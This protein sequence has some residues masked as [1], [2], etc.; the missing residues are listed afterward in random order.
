MDP[1]GSRSPRGEAKALS[2]Q[3]HEPSQTRA[4]QEGRP[5][6][7]PRRDDWTALRRFL[8]LGSDGG[9]Y[10][11]SEFRLTR[12]AADAVERCIS[13]DGPRTVAEIVALCHDGRAPKREPALFALALAASIGDEPTRQVALDALPEV[14]RSSVDLFEFVAFVE[15]FRGWGRALRR[16]VGAWYATRPVDALAY[17]AVKHR[18]RPDRTHRDL[19]RLSHP[20]EQVSARNPTQPVSEEH[21]RLFEWIVRGGETDGLP[22]IVQGFAAAQTAPEPRDS[23]ALVGEYGLPPE[24]LRDEHLESDEV[25]AAL[26]REMP[27]TAIVRQLAALTEAGVLTAGSPATAEVVAALGN[28]E[29]VRRARIHPLALLAALRG[30]RPPA[31]QVR[32]ALDAAFYAAFENVEPTGRR[33]L[34]TLDVSGSMEIG[35]VAGVPGLTPRDAAAALA[36]IAVSRE[37]DCRIAGFYASDEGFSAPGDGRF[38]GSGDGLT[39][40]P[41]VAGQRLEE[42]VAAISGLPFGGTDCALP[43]LWAAQ[44]GAEID[45]FIVYTDSEPTTGVLSPAQALADYRRASGIDARLIVVGMVSGGLQVADPA[46]QRMLDVVG[47]DAATPQ[48]V[49]DFSRGAL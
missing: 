1:T 16:A 38:A 3:A 43:M 31:P 33:T 4:T 29:R 22:R 24:A 30:N 6:Y 42:A 17:Q 15:E 14:A 20:G 32:D 18:A 41:I 13:G 5:F 23:A 37:P 47:F 7:C 27:V 26:L 36:L 2:N 21:R 39:P 28:A 12:E 40:L 44:T 45:T 11:A 49:A 46:D 8:I 35:Q 25:W 10:Y 34:V 19:L 48:L 9:S